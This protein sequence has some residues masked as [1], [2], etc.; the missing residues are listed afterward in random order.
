MVKKDAEIKFRVDKLTME[1]AQLKAR[2]MD[3]PLSQILRELL[4]DW[5][6]EDDGKP[7]EREPQNE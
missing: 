4:R 3:V 2:E 7:K 5:I 6:S 1:A